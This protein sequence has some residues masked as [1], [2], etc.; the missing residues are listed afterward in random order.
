MTDYLKYI[1]LDP[2]V[3]FGKPCILGTRIALLDILQWL[4]SGMTYDEILED[5]PLLNKNH[6]LA[7]LTFA[8]HKEEMTKMLKSNYESAA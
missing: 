3:R 7:A 8:A 6:I 5:Y 4:A 1:S 2:N